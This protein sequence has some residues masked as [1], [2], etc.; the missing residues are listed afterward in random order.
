MTERKAIRQILV[1][2][3]DKD[4][5][6]LLQ[7]GLNPYGFEILAVDPES[8][9]IHTSN[10]FQAELIF[11]AVE[12]PDMLGYSLYD[13]AR[14]K[15]GKYIPIV[16]TTATLSMDDFSLHSQL[17]E[18]ADAYLDKR[19]LVSEDIPFKILKLIGLKPHAISSHAGVHH[20]Q[21]INQGAKM[22]SKLEQTLS[23]IKNEVS[24]A[25]ERLSKESHDTRPSQPL[26]YALNQKKDQNGQI[27][28]E[29][30][31]FV[32]K[33]QEDSERIISDKDKLKKFKKEMYDFEKEIDKDLKRNKELAAFVEITQRMI[34]EAKKSAEMLAKEKLTHQETRKQLESKIAQLQAELIGNKEQYLFQLNASE[35]KFKANLLKAKEE[36]QRALEDLNQSYTAQISQLR[37]EKNA[38]IKALKEK[39]SAEMQKIAEMLTDKEKAYQESNKQYEHKIAHLQ[40]ELEDAKKQQISQIQAVEEKHKTD[41]L[42]TEGHHSNIVDSIVKKFAAQMAQ[43]RIDMDKE[44]QTHQKIRED[45]ETKIAQLSDQKDSAQEQMNTDQ[46]VTKDEQE[47]TNLPTGDE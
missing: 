12:A 33:I 26:N 39:V 13:R 27:D 41:L 9:K 23:D 16:L 17:K 10:L 3:N 40:A 5:V 7:N 32:K 47:D 45:F 43:A 28:R 34:E 18:P 11:I 4:F 20:D 31:D 46:K 19:R 29:I 38:E 42:S 30:N 6:S 36:Q 2:D 15:I 21:E 25:F 35:E 44:R 14:R 22:M 24:Q 8:D 1:L 37:I